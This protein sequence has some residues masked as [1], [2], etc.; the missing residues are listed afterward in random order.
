MTVVA[1][2]KLFNIRNSLQYY[3]PIQDVSNNQFYIF[4]ARNTPWP[5]TTPLPISDSTT[6]TEYTIFEELIFGKIVTPTDTK[7][8]VD[9]NDW[10]SGTIY[11]RYDDQDGDLFSK[12]F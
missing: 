7:M 6:E 1:N 3:Q 9:R 2:T 10:T 5:N 11:A 4:A 12:A 8:M